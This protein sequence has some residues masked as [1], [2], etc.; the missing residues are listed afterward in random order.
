MK[1]KKFIRI[2]ISICVLAI[3]SASIYTLACGP[4]YDPDST[5]ISLFD[6][7][8]SDAPNTR[9]FY[10]SYYSLFDDNSFEADNHTNIAEWKSYTLGFAK[11]KD[12]SEIVYKVSVKQLY[13]LKI[14]LGTNKMLIIDD[15]LKDNT[16][17]QY[18]IYK[19][20]VATI[21]YLIYAKSCESF[22]YK[23]YDD[24]WDYKPLE[25]SKVDTL[26]NNGLI[27]YK[28]TQ[29]QFLKLRYGFQV[30]RLAHY[31]QQY[32][33][34]ISIYD[35]LISPLSVK[36]DVN[37][38]CLSLKAGA[39][40]KL[41]QQPLSIYLF[42]KVFDNCPKYRLEAYKSIRFFN[43]INEDSVLNFCINNHE[44]AVFYTI[45]AYNSPLP[46]TLY[47]NK[48]YRLEPKSLDLE[49]LL[50]R[51]ISK[52]EEKLTSIQESELDIA[53]DIIYTVD[54]INAA[55]LLKQRVAQIADAGNTANPAL[56]N[57]ALAYISYLQKDFKSADIYLN[58]IDVNRLNAKLSTQFNVVKILVE[59][60]KTE[61]ITTATEEIIL[62]YIKS[63]RDS[64]IYKKEINNEE[65]YDE[66]SS[67]QF[68]FAERAY[69]TL[70]TEIL[71]RNY[72]HQGDMIKALICMSVG[73][74]DASYYPT[75]YYSE[76][77]LNSATFKIMDRKASTD[78]LLAILQFMD[79]PRNNE[80]DNFICNHSGIDRSSLIELIGTKFI[81]LSDFGNAVSVLSINPE[82][83][84]DDIGNYIDAN[85]F[86]DTISESHAKTSADTVI[87][88][89][90]NFAKRMFELENLLKSNPAN[91]TSYYYQLANAYYNISYYGNSWA[92]SQYNRSTSET[93]YL[94]K[95]LKNNN[96]YYNTKKALTYFIKAMNSSDN[97]EFKARCTMLASKSFL[98][99]STLYNYNGDKDKYE[100]GEY[101]TNNPYFTSL[102]KDYRK[103]AFYKQAIGQCSYLKDFVEIYKKK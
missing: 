73:E 31:S 82:D 76:S 13:N 24:F 18:L 68:V 3:L 23:N 52:I 7:A 35:S 46:D 55:G 101:F 57:I 74:F 14:N 44:R 47:I 60:N 45:M 51:E 37:Y 79:S 10:Y 81:R 12:I 64:F 30:Q 61:R 17:L 50:I 65:G 70:M 38:W 67:L 95:S 27:A 83:R 58:K 1:Q 29:N 80:Y 87:Y 26:L 5:N 43:N 25:S 34:C 42:S 100:P 91:A 28:Q 102:Y 94:D 62:P 71:S 20:D 40:F 86:G 41:N 63:L 39:L 75:T 77:F 96:D 6:K 16:F 22:V 93:E 11:E 69:A 92:I 56:W 59:I 84:K 89:K 66:V 33:R 49:V 99:Q 54:V 36:S 19:K 90:L 53:N 78:Q 48:I 21:N 85:P 4:W 15:S 88:T 72:A 8:L 98:S 32:E 103:T 97:K 2:S 9:P